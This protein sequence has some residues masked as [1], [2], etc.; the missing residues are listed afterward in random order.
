MTPFKRPSP[1]T[2]A[3]LLVLVGTAS[4]V[5]GVGLVLGTGWALIAAGVAAAAAGLTVDI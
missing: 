3:V 4:V 5:T 2:L 1:A